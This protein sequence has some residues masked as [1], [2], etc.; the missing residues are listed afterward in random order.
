MK[1][2]R[3]SEYY[4]TD[5]ITRLRNEVFRLGFIVVILV[6]FS[7]KRADLFRIDEGSWIITVINWIVVFLTLFLAKKTF[8][9]RTLD[10]RI[11]DFN[12]LIE[13]KEQFIPIWIELY[14]LKK[15]YG[16]ITKGSR[17]FET[18]LKLEFDLLELIDYV[19]VWRKVTSVVSKKLPRENVIP[20]TL[21]FP[22]NFNSVRGIARLIGS[23]KFSELLIKKAL[24]HNII[25]EISE[26]KNKDILHI[27]Y[28]NLGYIK[29]E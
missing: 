21:L 1:T 22:E 2:K 27:R 17:D 18:S 25:E 5:S 12:T 14:N 13:S 6:F 15:D 19:S 10:L 16:E 3:I 28:K 7:T 4:R 20:T 24:Q 8:W 23:Q 26:E 9:L 29:N 11:K